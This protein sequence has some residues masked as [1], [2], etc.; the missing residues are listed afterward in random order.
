MTHELVLPKPN[1]NIIWR[2]AW[3]SFFTSI[4]ALSHPDTIY[5]AIIPA[6]VF[7]TS[8]NYWRDPVRESW[9][10]KTDMM[11][12]YSGISSQ[13]LYVY[14]YL[15]DKKVIQYNYLYFYLIFTSFMCYLISEYYLKRDR[16]WPA[17]YFHACIHIIANIANIVLCE[18]V[19][20]ENRRYPE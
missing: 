6:S 20:H 1:A 5:F 19:V 10:R 2:V 14:L 4:Y 7:A 16:I 3:C 15:T 9:R 13:S 17:T 11:I 12:V 18:G 8:L